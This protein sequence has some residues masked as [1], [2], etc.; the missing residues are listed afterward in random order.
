MRQFDEKH[1]KRV[2]WVGYEV[3]NSNF[4][5]DFASSPGD[6]F[7]VEQTQ[8]IQNPQNTLYKVD[9]ANFIF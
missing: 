8:T 7:W 6:Q 3:A 9:H 4:I 2:A 1:E 5:A